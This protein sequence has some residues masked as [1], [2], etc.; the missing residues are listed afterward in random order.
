M[1]LASSPNARLCG[2]ALC[3]A[4]TLLLAGCGGG[5]SLGFGTGIGIGV[6]VGGTFGDAF[7]RVA[8]SVSLTT[9][10]TSVQAGRN[11][12]LAAAAADESGIESVTFFRLDGDTPVV[13]ATLGAAPYEIEVT[14]PADGRTLVT[15]FTRATDNAGNRADSARVAVTVTP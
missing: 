3:L 10:A 9:A 11:I 5:V 7:D 14:A 4:A 1:S 6:G 13:L 12:R 8:P 15:Y 2:R